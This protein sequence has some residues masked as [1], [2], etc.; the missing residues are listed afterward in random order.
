[1]DSSTGQLRRAW[2]DPVFILMV[3][4]MLVAVGSA[5]ALR[6]A[7]GLVP[8][9]ARAVET[10]DDTA[11]PLMTYIPPAHTRLASASR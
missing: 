6:A 10:P 1:M 7:V 4:A 2:R 11:A 9:G 8:N 3:A 5:F